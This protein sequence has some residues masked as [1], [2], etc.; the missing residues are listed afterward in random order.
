MKFKFKRTISI[1]LAV[2]IS[3]V[4]LGGCAGGKKTAGSD[5]VTWVVFA[6]ERVDTPR[7]VEMMQ[8]IVLEKTGQKLELQYV[9]GDAYDLTVSSGEAIDLISA[10]DHQNFWPN[11]EKGAFME[12]TDEDLQEY[13]PYIWENLQSVI[14][15]PKIKGVRY[16]VPGLHEYAADRCFAARG[17][18]MEKYGIEDLNSVENIEK[19]LDAVKAGEPDLIPFDVPGSTPYLNLAMFA[20]DWGW[21][22]VSS[23]SF[24]EH[25]YFDVNDP[26]RKLFIA[27]EQPEMLEFT[28]RMKTWNEKGYFSKSVL[29]NKTSSLDSF[30]SGRTALAFVNSPAECQDVWKEFSQDDRAAWDVKFYSRYQ[31]SQAMYNVM[32]TCAAIS[33]FSDNKEGALKV[34]NE[35]YANEELYKL[36]TYGIEGEHYT[37]NENG[38]YVPTA[39]DEDR[40]WL[41]LGVSNDNWALENEI[42]FPGS[43]ELIQKLYDQRIVNPAVDMPKDDTNTREIEV[44]LS[45][46]YSQYTG[47]RMYGSFQGT[48]QEALDAE[49]KAL[50]TAG[51]DKYIEEIQKQLDAYLKSTGDI[52]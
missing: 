25:I 46:V 43:E 35:F 41:S 22:P 38:K 7:I 4:L 27:A 3:A 51:I 2:M 47:P 23:L 30:K 10:A 36:L 21:Q 24:G 11:A 45:E 32:N 20:S 29:S 16:G 8:Q 37:L 49:V 33:A 15:I 13:A 5:T 26:E 1:V 19:Y 44:A 52:K 31:K 14:N 6:T 40:G 39:K 17:D 48:A 9:S 28:E 18:L 12:I 42:N 34:L 50:K